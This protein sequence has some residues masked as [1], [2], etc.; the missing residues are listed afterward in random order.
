MIAVLIALN[1][2]IASA[3]PYIY[4]ERQGQRFSVLRKTKREHVRRICF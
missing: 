3:Q 2:L 4:N 1:M